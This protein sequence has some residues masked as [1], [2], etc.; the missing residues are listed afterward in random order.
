MN[1]VPKTAT[2]DASAPGWTTSEFWM[3]AVTSTIVLLNS[4]F[5]WNI[6]PVA[7]ATVAGMIA[8]YALARM[9]TKRAVLTPPSSGTGTATATVTK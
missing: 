1:T 7:I 4:A 9:G 5:G 6:D 3:A 2:A 8:A